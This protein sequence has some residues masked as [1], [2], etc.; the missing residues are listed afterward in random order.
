MLIQAA[1]SACFVCAVVSLVARVFRHTTSL[2]A[3]AGRALSEADDAQTRCDALLLA[4]GKHRRE[5]DDLRARLDAPRV[6]APK[7]AGPYRGC[8]CP[9]HGGRS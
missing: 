5:L 3:V 2:R 1:V 6:A 4:L 9:C 8:G 7:P